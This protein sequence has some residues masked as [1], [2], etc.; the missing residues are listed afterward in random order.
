MVGLELD[1]R[2]DGRRVT[3]TSGSKALDERTCRTI[4]RRARYTPARDTEGKAV[5]DT[6]ALRIRWE[7]F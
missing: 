2:A 7:V 6:V 4:T 3:S 5:P 1:V